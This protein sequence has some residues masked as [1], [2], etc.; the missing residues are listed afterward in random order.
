MG[1][2]VLITK[3]GG[4]GHRGGQTK[5]SMVLLALTISN[6]PYTLLEDRFITNSAGSSS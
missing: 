2:I 4:L 3:C 5:E 6:S 1:I